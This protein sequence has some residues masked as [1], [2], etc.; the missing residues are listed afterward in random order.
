[1]TAHD[2]RPAQEP[3]TPAPAIVRGNISDESSVKACIVS[4]REHHSP[5]PILI[6]NA[7]ITG[8]SLISYMGDPLGGR[9]KDP[10]KKH[11]GHVPGY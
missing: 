4:A 5:I 9:A 11:P 8:E 7:R 2:V 6:A 3:S 1:M 10:R